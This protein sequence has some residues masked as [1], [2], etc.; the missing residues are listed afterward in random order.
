MPYPR[1]RAVPPAA[2][3]ITAF[4][5][6]IALMA[7]GDAPAPPA[8]PAHVAAIT[9]AIAPL[10]LPGIDVACYDL[11]VDSRVEGVWSAPEPLCTARGSHGALTQEVACDPTSD[12]DPTIDGTQ[13]RV[14]L[15]VSGLYAADGT[16]LG[17][18]V[19]PCPGGCARTVDCGHPAGDRLD[20]DLTLARRSD[21]GFFDAGIA[22]GAMVCSARYDC[23]AGKL[24]DVA[25]EP[26][27]R[28][29]LGFA[30]VG[31]LDGQVDP[32]LYLDPIV[33]TCDDGWGPMTATFDPET[34]LGEDA[35]PTTAEDAPW[36]GVAFSGRFDRL[37]QVAVRTGM[38]DGQVGLARVRTRYWNVDL[39]LRGDLSGCTLTARGTMDDETR[40]GG[41]TAGVVPAGGI[42]P[43]VDWTVDLGACDD[44]NLLDRP[45]SGVA[46][47]YF[48]DGGDHRFSHSAPW[49]YASCAANADCPGA[50]CVAGTCRPTAGLGR[51]CDETDDCIEGALCAAGSCA[52]PPLLIT[53]VTVSVPVGGTSTFAAA[54][55]EG[56]YIFEL[57]SG[58]GRL[59]GATYVA[60]D[61]EGTAVVRVRDAA[62]NVREAVVTVVGVPLEIAPNAAWVPVGEAYPFV[63]TGGAPPYRFAVVAGAGEIDPTTGVYTAPAEP[64]DAMVRVTDGRGD[65]S[66]AIVHVTAAP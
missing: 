49:G 16:A 8:P 35:D 51:A 17:D 62:G 22:V 53:P 37:Q 45:E 25:G 4:L 21:R 18:W 57:A 34:A 48:V 32:V 42:Y 28:Q 41:A 7:C 12:V 47:R 2:P 27:V 13:N 33:V 52:L 26:V 39:A 66:N 30:C 15:S 44:D 55:G 6:A 50:V 63:A 65:G 60:P 40:L 23:A 38:V 56:G 20:V 54:G 10:D 61:V 24:P 43:Y 14:I 11:R 9:V 31:D 46:T 59:D 19:D 3:L 5:F 64:G 29:L 36:T 1:A 58:H